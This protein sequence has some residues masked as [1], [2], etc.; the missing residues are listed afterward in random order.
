M[1][2]L[3]MIIICILISGCSISTTKKPT[4]KKPEMGGYVGGLQGLTA[5]L[6]EGS[7]PDVIQDS[8]ITPFSF[9]VSLENAGEATVGKGTDNP[10]VFVRLAGISYKDFNMKQ[11]EAAI[12]F[13]DKLEPVKRNYDDSVTPGEISYV[14]FDNLAYVN[15]V[16][17]SIALTLRAEV[18]YDYESYAT[19]KFCVKREV[20]ESVED[21]TICVLRGPRPFGNSGAP[22]Q[23]TKVEEAPI[24]N[25]TVQINFNIEHL[26]NG[27]FFF[28]NEPTDLFD[29]C[30]FSDMNP[31]RYK[32]EVFVEPVQANMYNV[33]CQRLDGSL[34][35]GGAHGVVKM[36]DGAP[37]ALTCFVKRL[38]P[39]ESRVYQ[40]LLNIK[41]RYRY[42]EF[43]EKPILIQGY[44]S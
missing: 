1:A 5:R 33:S 43:I 9:T 11:E 44:E 4:Q 13:D 39:M 20:F 21:S 16:S 17:E 24:N 8:G 41:L 38:K 18:C 27:V 6:L 28:R 34:P 35:G 37:L 31:N 19:A 14:G 32:L 36:P 23:V 42:G 12:R 29:A 25:N 40:D 22:L 15:H 2:F 7:P 3:V 10:L 26:G 30:V